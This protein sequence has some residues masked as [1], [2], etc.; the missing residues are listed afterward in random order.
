MAFDALEVAVEL[1]VALRAPLAVL[2]QHDRGLEEQAKQA[3][4]SVALCLDEGRRRAGKDRLHLFRVAAGSAAEVRTALRLA[5]AWG[6]LGPEALAPAYALLDR[7]LAMLW[8][9]APPR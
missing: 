7:E 6:Y 2:R 4:N 8:R 5:E 3:V 9:L 1:A